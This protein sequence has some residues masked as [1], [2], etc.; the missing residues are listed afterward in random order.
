LGAAKNAGP[1][2]RRHEHL[3][4]LRQELRPP[5]AEEPLRL[6]IDELDLSAGVDHHHRAGRRFH[7]LAEALCLA[8]K[9]C[10]GRTGFGL[11]RNA[12]RP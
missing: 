4:R 7:H 10:L 3:D 12:T 2:A 11:G 9:S 8:S 1:E 6:D 5:V